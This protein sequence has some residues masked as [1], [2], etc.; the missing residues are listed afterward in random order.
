L[1][2]FPTRVSQ[3]FRTIDGLRRGAGALTL[4]LGWMA[5]CTSSSQPSV[6]SS[7]P[8]TMDQYCQSPNNC[9]FGFRADVADLCYCAGP[10]ASS[11]S[12]MGTDTP[13][14]GYLALVYGYIWLYDPQT[15]Q[16]IAILDEAGANCI[17]GPTSFTIPSGC[18]W[19]NLSL[20]CRAYCPEGGTND[21]GAADAIPDGISE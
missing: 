2:M 18:A 8:T 9:G 12:L 11:V 4:A 6:R 13:C 5:A 15:G 7:C 1:L 10:G 16:R 17:A 21:A 3:A 14:G 19:R 20:Q